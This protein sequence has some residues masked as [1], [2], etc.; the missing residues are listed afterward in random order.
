LATVTCNATMRKK[1][2][3][4]VD[5]STWNIYNFRLGLI[6]QLKATGYDVLVI[7]PVDEYIH[8][9][10]ES[11]I[12]RH[13][14]LHY[15]A[16]QS[17][18]PL[19][20]MAL[21]VE[22]WDIYRREKP[23][24]ILHYTI[25]PNIYGNLAA[26]LAGVDAMSTITG[27][28]YTFLHRSLINRMV[29][30]LY[31]IAFKYARRVIFYNHEDRDLFIKK[32]IIAPHKGHIIPGSGVNVNHFRPLSLPDDSTFVFL[33]IGRLLYDKGLAEF[34]EAARQIRQQYSHAE[35]WVIGEINAKNPAAVSKED[36]LH[37]MEAQ[38]IRYWGV[39]ADVRQYIKKAHV[40]VLPS[41]REGVPR[42]ILEAMAM[43]KPIITT[44]VA[45]C[46]D[47]VKAG[48]N[49]FL[50]PPADA[51]AL[52]QAMRKALLLS[53]DDYA[54]MGELSRQIAL[55]EFDEKLI[56]HHYINVIRDILHQGPA[57]PAELPILTEIGG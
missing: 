16:P 44:D 24:L 38:D 3:A 40:V 4:I 30:A 32:E 5:N 2:I 51:G 25:K 42:S 41:Y 43:G 37:W 18:N 27:L 8:Y 12:V 1:T 45:G 53:A 39:V 33:F 55:S 47:T 14:P 19:R 21:V 35:C 22:L 9:L 15:L 26:W 48:L 49:G 20:D 7:A 11:G 46:R 52:A 36:M 34:V 10:N 54:S 56:T 31:R 17:N 23:D 28:G 13:I 50:V 29:P 57:L 6:K